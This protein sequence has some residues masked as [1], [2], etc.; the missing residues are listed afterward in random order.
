MSETHELACL[1]CGQ[2]LWIG[3]G[4]GPFFTTYTE[5]DPEGRRYLDLFLSRHRGPE[6]HLLVLSDHEENVTAHLVD[7]EWGPDR[8]V[9]RRQR[10]CRACGCTPLDCSGCAERS[11]GW[12]CCWVE[13]DLCSACV[14]PVY[15]AN[16]LCGWKVADGPQTVPD[17]SL[18]WWVKQCP[19]WLDR[20]DDVGQGQA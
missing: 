13:A 5:R 14:V 20:P 1:T 19:G 3:Q 18:P 8:Q 11:G 15:G 6:H 7:V 17:G 12:P 9:L 4:S 16:G 2:K 10:T